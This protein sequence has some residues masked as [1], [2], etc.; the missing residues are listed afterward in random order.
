[1]IWNV[2]E[3]DVAITST[4]GFRV[5]LFYSEHVV[6]DALVVCLCVCKRGRRTST[7]TILFFINVRNAHC[8]IMQF[9]QF[10]HIFI[11]SVFPFTVRTREELSTN[12]EL[13]E[14]NTS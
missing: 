2:N 8:V 6:L 4:N 14:M 10:F 12:L 7:H 3:V 1:M 9:M 5:K 13:S 11:R